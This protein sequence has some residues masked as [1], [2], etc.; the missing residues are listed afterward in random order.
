VS[1]GALPTAHAHG[2][3]L[4]ITG[5][6]PR[7]FSSY[8]DFGPAQIQILSSKKR[9]VAVSAGRRF[10]KTMTGLYRVLCDV[11]SGPQRIG[12]YIGPTERQAEEMGWRP[13]LDI[14]PAPLIRRLRHSELQIELVNGSLIKL[15]GPQSLRGPGLDFAFLDE[16]AYM[17]PELWPEVVRPMLADREGGAL[18]AST[19]RG[20]NHFYDLYLEAQTRADW[21]AF[22]FPTSSGGYVSEAELELLRAT[23]DPKQFAQEIL[24]SF[25]LQSGRVYHAFSR[26]LN[27]T[28]VPLV[29]GPKL[30]VGMDFNVNPMTAVIT[31]KI[32]DECH[33]SDEIVLPNSNTFEMME[34]LVRRYPEQHG[35][36]YPDP[37]CTARKT[38]ASVGETDHAIIRRS[39]WDVYPTQQHPI[40]DRINNV[41][42]M[43]Q[44]A[45]GK[46]RLFI[47]H[48][49]KNL[50]RSLES[51]TYKEGTHVPDKSSGHDHIVDALGY[52]IVVVFPMVRHEVTFSRVQ[53]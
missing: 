33:V 21:A 28:D 10:G 31:Q 6:T 13:L 50:I 41:N 2:G 53:I 15:H 51:L 29:H 19:P 5:P 34:E 37:S 39:G 48:K 38:S 26:H 27:V 43:F 17:P 14:V 20:L 40:V 9:F 42:A 4:G 23:M 49:C 1:L 35:V 7:I 12:Y 22:R 25:E 30:L 24:A 16:F 44:N 47:G 3:S 8:Q 46:P 52:L 32:G 11:L 45:N 36:V 18:L